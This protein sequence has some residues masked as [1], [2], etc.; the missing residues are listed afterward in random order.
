[1]LSKTLSKKA[2]GVRGLTGARF[3]AAD[4]KRL[5][6][7]WIEDEMRPESS[8]ADLVKTFDTTRRYTVSRS[9]G[10]VDLPLTIRRGRRE[11]I[12]LLATGTGQ[13]RLVVQQLTTKDEIVGGSTFLLRG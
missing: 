1:L 5:R 6:R 10:H 9:A 8:W 7:R 13:E 3:S 2:D 11:Q 4:L 12:L